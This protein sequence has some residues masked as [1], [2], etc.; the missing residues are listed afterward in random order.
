[1]G[2]D[3]EMATPRPASGY[4]EK[5]QQPARG[6]NR[7]EESTPAM[8]EMEVD[9]CKEKCNELQEGEWSNSGADDSADKTSQRA[10][11][12]IGSIASQQPAAFVEQPGNGIEMMDWRGSNSQKILDNQPSESYSPPTLNLSLKRP[13]ARGEMDTDADDQR[14]LRHSGNSAFSR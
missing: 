13:R 10:I 14:M 8:E 5:S 6:A 1:M 11:D 12:L 3:L 9:N 2:Q 4:V 7:N